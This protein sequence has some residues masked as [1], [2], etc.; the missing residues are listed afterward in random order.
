MPIHPP[1]CNTSAYHDLPTANNQLN[2]ET[3]KRLEIESNHISNRRKRS[4]SF[5]TEWGIP[6]VVLTWKDV[7]SPSIYGEN[8][9]ILKTAS[10]V[11]GTLGVS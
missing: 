7:K 11:D 8:I 3:G 2:Q 1:P 9:G 5:I 6:C 4:K 10:N